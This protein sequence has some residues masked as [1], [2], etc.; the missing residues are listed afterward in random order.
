MNSSTKV[1]IF[2]RVKF[3]VCWIFLHVHPLG[4]PGSTPSTNKDASSHMES[5]LK[6]FSQSIYILK[7]LDQTKI[8]LSSRQ[9]TSMWDM[10]YQLAAFESKCATRGTF[11]E[12]QNRQ[13]QLQEKKKKNGKTKNGKTTEIMLWAFCCLWTISSEKEHFPR[14]ILWCELNIPVKDFSYWSKNRVIL[15]I[16]V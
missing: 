12:T 9:I 4:S 1:V 14:L 6:D 15:Q 11:L 13:E 16:S 3:L 2:P 10:N 8:L 7:S 5:E